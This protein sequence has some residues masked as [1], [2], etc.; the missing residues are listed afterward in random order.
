MFRL[1]SS[2]MHP[3]VSS[4]MTKYHLMF[5]KNKFNWMFYVDIHENFKILYEILKS[6]CVLTNFSSD[7][8]I[9]RFLGKGHFAEVYSVTNLTTKK[10]FA[11]KIFEK[12]SESFQKNSVNFILI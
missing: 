2:I 4:P 12:D 1:S 7:Y 11:A 9:S 3:T 6:F 5:M 8:E 10:R